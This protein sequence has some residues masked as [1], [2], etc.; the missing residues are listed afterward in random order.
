MQRHPSWTGDTVP[1]ASPMLPEAKLRSQGHPQFPNSV[2]N[3]SISHTLLA[4]LTY[5]SRSGSPSIPQSLP[6]TG[7]RCRIPIPPSTPSSPAQGLGFP[8]HT[9]SSLYNLSFSDLFCPLGCC[10]SFLL[11][12]FPFS[13]PHKAQFSLSGP[14]WTLPYVPASGCALPF[15]YNKLSP[16]AFQGPVMAFLF[17][18]FLLFIC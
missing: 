6:V 16:S 4:Y 2:K 8:S 9:S 13:S 14:L 15:I 10:T 1:A 12:L 17:L 7:Y 11:S 3:S 5:G 18:L